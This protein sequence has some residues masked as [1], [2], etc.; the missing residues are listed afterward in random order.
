M[1]GEQAC[2][3]HMRTCGPGGPAVGRPAQ[4]A[5]TDGARGQRS[6]PAS[7]RK[8]GGGADWPDLHRRRSPDDE[9][10]TIGFLSPS[11]TRRSRCLGP[12]AMESAAAESS[13]FGVG[14]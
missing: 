14:N 9:K 13:M 12:D 1:R 8:A 10:V 7:E 11:W 2:G 5:M 6:P 3:A 4:G